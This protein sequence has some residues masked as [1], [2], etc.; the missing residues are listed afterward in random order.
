[1]RQRNIYQKILNYPGNSNGFRDADCYTGHSIFQ[2]PIQPVQHGAVP[3][4]DIGRFE[5]PV[6]LVGK[7]EE[8]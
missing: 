8:F 5:N 7:D 2:P 4:E 3:K 1:V 6:A